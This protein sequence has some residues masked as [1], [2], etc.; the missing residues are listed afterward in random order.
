M[1]V[2]QPAQNDRSAQ[3]CRGVTTS[4]KTARH[5]RHADRLAA[6]QSFDVLDTPREEEFDDICALAAEI[7]GT[8]VALISLVDD[9]RQWFKAE[10]G[11]GAAQ[12]SLRESICAHAILQDDM[13]EIPDTRMDERT[14]DNPLVT[15]KD[16][17]RFY[18]GAVLETDDGLPIGTLCTLDYQP[19]RLTST[20]KDT[21]RVLARQVMTQLQLRRALVQQKLMAQE[22]DHRVKNSLQSITSIVRLQARR[23]E[24]LATKSVLNELERRIGSIA[25]LHEALHK[26]SSSEKVRLDSLMSSISGYLQQGVVD[27]I[28]VESHFDRIMIESKQAS[29]IALLANEF[30]ANSIKHAFP[31]A[32]AGRIGFSGT[33]MEDGT[34]RIVMEDDGIG[35][36]RGSVSGDGLGLKIIDATIAQ[37]N[38]TIEQ[39]ADNNGVRLVITVPAA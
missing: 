28:Q 19:R 23:S 12:T 17:F 37:L 15:Q 18:A 32:Q 2:H 16:G 35:F 29:A 7:C 34:L 26:A 11:L 21:L 39:D 38:A 9:N 20:Q 1:N 22:I 33:R 14:A 30:T 8:P 13:L 4:A 3:Q 31:K 24:N 5:P 27:S 10:I 36:D 6:L 25:L